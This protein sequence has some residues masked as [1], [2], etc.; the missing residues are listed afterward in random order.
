MTRF[1]IIF[2]VCAAL[3][4]FTEQAVAEGRRVALVVGIGAYQNVPM[5][6][7]AVND[8]S[9]MAEMF[10]KAGFEVVTAQSDLGNLAFKRAIR[11]FEEVVADSDI[12]VVYYAGHGIEVRETNYL[13][14]TD[15]KLLNERDVEDEA[16]SLDRLTSAIEQAKRLRLIILDACRD[17][18]FASKMRRRVATRGIPT[19]LGKVEP[20]QTD[21]L[22]AYAAKDKSLA[23]DGEG[24][25]SP[26]TKALLTN[27]TEPGLDIRIAFGRV[28][29]DVLKA[30]GR[31]QEPFVYGSL[32]GGTVALVPASAGA[33]GG[34]DSAAKDDYGAVERLNSREA[35]EAFLGKHKGGFYADLARVQIAKLGTSDL[36]VIGE[37]TT[38]TT[39]QPVPGAPPVPK[40]RMPAIVVDPKA[41]QAEKAWDKL[42]SSTDLKA[43]RAFIARYPDSS[44][45]GVAQRRV[46]ILERFAREQ[47]A[48]VRAERE[49]TRLREEED[50]RRKVAE[51]EV[52]RLEREAA[53]LRDQE[54]KARAAELRRQKAEAEAAVRE[55]EAEERAKT[56]AA[57]AER[58]AEE[59]RA[60]AAEA[61]LRR[62]EAEDRAQ[63]M[64]AE[65]QKTADEAAVRRK[66]A[67]ETARVAAAAR[68]AREAEALERVRQAQEIDRQE[69]VRA[70]EIAARE[71][72]A[73]E[74]ARIAEMAARKKETGERAQALAAEQQKATEDAA[75]R[76][77]ES[78]EAARVAA[79][80]KAAREA[81]ALER[82][83]Q[84]QEID[85]QERVRAAEI[86]AREKEAQERA[87]IAEAE[88]R[89]A[90]AQAAAQR[91]QEDDKIKLATVD[92]N[93]VQAEAEIARRKSEEATKLAAAER[94]MRA[95]AVKQREQAEEARRVAEEATANR[96]RT[97]EIA[98][99]AAEHQASQAEAAADKR[100]RAAALARDEARVRTA[101]VRAGVH[102]PAPVRVEAQAAP[103]RGPSFGASEIGAARLMGRMP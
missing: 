16:I 101:Q 72:E 75:A 89:K 69:R 42:D 54:E 103:A 95:A 35:W 98:R 26:F 83:R 80:V 11:E 23:N 6:P 19:G 64:L 20:S 47:D 43:V 60:K 81:E 68:A 71:K 94:A 59:E 31:Q 51:A 86:A 12:A 2:I 28:R 102:A 77:R 100:R 91:R 22:I 70:A 66:E 17:N 48:A 55:R 39:E 96:K 67:E 45:A 90:E 65:R 63:A 13:V 37:A 73:Q 61:A 49:A 40:P 79:A 4:L 10:R 34:P 33:V 57:L 46:E 88:R 21:T 44:L 8:A 93:R 76:K 85:R 38:R 97:A 82:V 62:R 32:G 99:R 52:R 87:R 56:T 15:A 84:A 25:H 5:L 30:T 24:D 3:M 7:N 50:R 29:D 78:D 53:L 14:P 41:A 36:A 58:R 92:Q 9:A 74:R 18:P 27:L 1:P